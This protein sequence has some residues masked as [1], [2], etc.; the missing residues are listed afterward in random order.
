MG[1][2]TFIRPTELKFITKRK[3]FDTIYTFEFTADSLPHWKAGQHGLL[4]LKTS[5]GKKV[6]RM[7]SVSSAPE[8]GIVAITTRYN[9]TRASEFKK[10][11]WALEPGMIARLR[12]PVGPMYVRSSK[13][14]SVFI[15][16]GVGITPF[17]SMLA[18]ASITTKPIKGE[19]IY[20]V[21]DSEH[22][23]FEPDLKKF[24]HTMP[25]FKMRLVTSQ[26]DFEDAIAKIGTV[27]SAT[28]YISGVPKNVKVYKKSLR[29][30]GI[31]K[32]NIISDPFYGYK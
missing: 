5:T 20:K 8:E 3:Q 4:E 28:F 30:H 2:K 10:A 26:S 13:H 6:R 25:D 29:A 32:S 17:R 7:F 18:H 12:G 19:L 24:I 9:P 31:K 22:V 23:L 15:A 14:M 1:L 16:E 11:L 21:A 27:T